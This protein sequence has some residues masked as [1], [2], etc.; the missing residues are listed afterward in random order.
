M[1]ARNEPFYRVVVSDA[2]NRPRGRFVDVLGYYDPRPDPA[3]IRID[4]ARAEAWIRKGAQPSET[5]R[6]LLQKARSGE[7]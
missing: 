7:A 5:V 2:R 6:R 3:Q 1:G 4:V